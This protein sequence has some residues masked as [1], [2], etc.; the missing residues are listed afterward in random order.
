VKRAYQVSLICG[1]CLFNASCATHTEFSRLFDHYFP[2][3]TEYVQSIY[4]RGYDRSMF[5][6]PPSKLA[7]TRHTYLYRAFHGDATAFHSFVHHPDRD[8][9]GEDGESWHYG[10]LLLLIRLG[11]DRFSELLAGENAATRK[12]VGYAI[13]PQVD[14]T[15]HQF[16]KTRA[17]YSYRY[18]RKPT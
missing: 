14:W 1:L 10:C 7:S 13:D 8:V 9:A 4:R 18:V 3:R 2:K 16:P 11:D 6:D 5:G 12:S 15:I 17:L